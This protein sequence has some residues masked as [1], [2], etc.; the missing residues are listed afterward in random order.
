MKINIKAR[1]KNK[2][3]VMSASALIISFVYRLLDVL[4]IVPHIAENEITELCAMAV[5]ILAFFG[6]LVDPTTDGFA[7][8]E[9]AL[10]YGTENDVRKIGGADE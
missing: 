8:S 6:V 2:V 1:L 3:F 9:R 7:D 10:T 4:G 5:N